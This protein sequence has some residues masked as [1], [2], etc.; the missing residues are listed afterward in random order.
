MSN[1]YAINTSTLTALGDAVRGATGKYTRTDLTE[2]V[3]LYTGT[4]E[5]GKN[6]NFAVVYTTEIS[7]VKMKLISSSGPMAEFKTSSGYFT[8]DE[9]GEYFYPVEQSLSWGDWRFTL[10][11][12]GANITEP[13]TYEIGITPYGADGNPML[14]EGEA[15]NTMTLSQMTDELNQLSPG[16]TMEELTISGEC[17]YRFTSGGWDWFLTKYGKKI[18]TRDIT[19]MSEAFNGSKVSSIDFDLNFADVNRGSVDIQG[20]FTRC[21]NLK[22]FP[23]TNSLRIGSASYLFNECRNIREINNEFLDGIDFSFFNNDYEWQNYNDMFGYCSS[24]RKLPTDFI[25]NITHPNQYGSNTYLY[26]GFYGC[27]NLDEAT[28]LPFPTDAEQYD[29]FLSGTFQNCSRLKEMTFET[30]EDGTPKVANWSNQVLDLS[31]N[32]GYYSNQATAREYITNYNCGIDF[33]N[34]E[35][36]DILTYQSR[37]NSPNWFSYNEAL[38]R[39]NKLSAI[40]TINSLPDTSAFA[41]DNG[42]N[43]IMFRGPAGSSTDGGAINTMTD[44]E[45]AVAAAKGWT[46]SFT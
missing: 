26:S 15:V 35:A 9:N 34:D 33:D 8:F 25:R 37:K 6:I 39:Y 30:N 41:N 43:T 45:I 24:L 28:N 17:A 27:Y 12:R 22:S 2:I 19:Y 40:N 31:L 44:E 1:A 7:K 38:S 4:V 14:E 18:T 13:F 42:A 5:A 29:D 36:F 16:P 20:L 32:T 11:V 21:V 23:K 10:F 46:V 3:D